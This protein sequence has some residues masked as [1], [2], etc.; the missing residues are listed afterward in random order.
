MVSFRQILSPGF[1]AALVS[2]Y[3]G[4]ELDVRVTKDKR[5]IISHDEDLSA[6]TTLHGYVKDK[7]L[8][9]FENAL[10]IKSAFIPEKKSTA[11]EAF[12]AAPMSSLSMY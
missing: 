9:D 7:N 10:V 8:S 6:A 4:F 2:G 12:I 3:K 11:Y 1:E 5:F